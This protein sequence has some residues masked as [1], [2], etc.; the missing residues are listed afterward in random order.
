MEGCTEAAAAAVKELLAWLELLHSLVSCGAC[1]NLALLG[2]LDAPESALHGP[3]GSMRRLALRSL[4]GKTGPGWCSTPVAQSHS[5]RW[6]DRGSLLSARIML[7]MVA[8]VFLLHNGMLAELSSNT[9]LQRD[10]KQLNK[11]PTEIKITIFLVQP[12]SQHAM[13]R[14]SKLNSKKLKQTTDRVMN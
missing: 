13:P 12:H 1:L 6:K 3:N 8:K 4:S 2:G 11:T 5:R 14:G 9:G 10:P 7:P